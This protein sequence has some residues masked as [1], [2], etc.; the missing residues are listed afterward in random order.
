MGFMIRSE[1]VHCTYAYTTTMCT[2]YRE[3]TVSKGTLRIGEIWIE[4]MLFG[5]SEVSNTD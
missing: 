4:I 3:A 1:H 5:R 2:Q